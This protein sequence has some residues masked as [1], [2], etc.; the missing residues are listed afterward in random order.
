MLLKKSIQEYE[1]YLKNTG[2][3]PKTVKGY[4]YELTAFNEYLVKKSNMPAT[5]EDITPKAI[6]DY[7][8]YLLTEKKYAPYSRR[9]IVIILKAYFTYAY[10]EGLTR[11]KL[12][13]KILS[14]KTP[15]KERKFL[16]VEEVQEFLSNVEN[17]LIRVA[18]ETMYYTG[19]RV[20]ECC[21]LKLVDVDMRNRIIHVVNGK[22]GKDRPIPI[23]NKLYDIFTDYISNWRIDSDWFFATE[24]TGALAVPTVEHTVAAVRKEMGWKGITPHTFRHS[25][26]SSLVEKDVNLLKIS[27]LL[28]HSSL[29]TTQIYI[30][31]NISQ[32]AD[33]VNL[34]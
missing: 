26:A 25:F 10:N 34:L 8:L 11:D 4:I 30:H 21:N 18:V 1:K 14:V 16:T 24:K 15:K 9:R 20:S 27:K 5:V 19:M 12:S 31:T 2:K 33:A 22:G 28:G 29:K 32:L 3:S 17:R 13:E 6:N 23:C 7:V